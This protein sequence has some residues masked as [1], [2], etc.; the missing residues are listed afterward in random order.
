MDSLDDAAEIEDSAVLIGYALG[1]KVRGILNVPL[2]ELQ[3]W[4]SKISSRIQTLKSEPPTPGRLC[5][6]LFV[7]GYVALNKYLK[8]V[9]DTQESIVR[10]LRN[11]A[12][13]A[14]AVW[15]KL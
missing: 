6:L 9:H 8:V 10:D 4:H 1:A 12:Q 11:G 2:T 3:G 5:S 13:D 15:H 7:E 14:V